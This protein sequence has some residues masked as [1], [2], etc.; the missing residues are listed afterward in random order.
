MKPDI[1]RNKK[2]ISDFHKGIRVSVIA[3]KY[4]VTRSQIW[5]VRKQYDP[6]Y[7]EVLTG[8]IK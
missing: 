2:L 4:G 6:K 1:I 8:D 7:K 3:Q 5:K